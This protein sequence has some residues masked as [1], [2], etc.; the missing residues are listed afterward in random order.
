MHQS[1]TK[2]V[3][4]LK[5]SQKGVLRFCT[6][7]TE[8]CPSVYKAQENVHKHT[9]VDEM[10]TQILKYNTPNVTDLIEFINALIKNVLSGFSGLYWQSLQ[11]LALETFVSD[12]FDIKS[13]IDEVCV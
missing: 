7:E 1:L 11:N 5:K 3:R 13:K 10:L 2:R 6:K 9:K 12:K 4:E 8:S